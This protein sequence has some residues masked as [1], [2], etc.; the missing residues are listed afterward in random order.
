MNREIKF[1]AWDGSTM[2]EITNLYW[3]EEEGVHGFDGIGHNKKYKLMQYT[4]LK[5]KNGKE[6]YE[7][8][9]ATKQSARG[10]DI[11]GDVYFDQGMFRIRW[12]LMK[13][14]KL[15]DSGRTDGVHQYLSSVLT[16]GW[17]VI[18]NV[19]ENPELLERSG[20]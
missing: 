6:I 13:G 8:D 17:E 19:F 4:G 3:F 12:G 14:G 11:I 10:N 1:R 2:E 18:G 7:G 15:A 5:D 20:L 16:G 9:V